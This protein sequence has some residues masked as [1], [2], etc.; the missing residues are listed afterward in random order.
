MLSKYIE[1]SL[2]YMHMFRA[3]LHFFIV[4]YGLFLHIHLRVASGALARTI[5][6]VPLADIGKNGSFES[7]HNYIIATEQQRT[8]GVQVQVQVQV[9][10]LPNRSTWYNLKS[11]CSSFLE[12][13]R[14]YIIR[15]LSR[16]LICVYFVKECV[17]PDTL[18]C[19]YV[20]A[21]N[22]YLTHWGRVMHICVS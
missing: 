8:N 1:Y 12:G 17:L 19:K 16:I 5:A 4:L 10:Y 2:K 15:I 9:F 20:R 14:T 11:V 13:G 18:D 6:P 3:L 7:T 22:R 21:S